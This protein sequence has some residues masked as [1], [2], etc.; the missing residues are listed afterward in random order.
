MSALPAANDDPRRRACGIPT[1][2]PASA[3]AMP[4]WC[5]PAAVATAAGLSYSSACALLNR[6]SPE[7]YPAGREIVRPG[8]AT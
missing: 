7:R 8:G 4:P 1:S 3:G 5:G 2:S 6:V